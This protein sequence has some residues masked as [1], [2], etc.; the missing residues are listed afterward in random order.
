MH[1]PTISAIGTTA[2]HR[3]KG[4]SLH[5]PRPTVRTGLTIA[6]TTGL[7]IAQT[8]DLTIARTTDPITGLTIAQTTAP[9]I[10][11]VIDL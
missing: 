3:R 11:L 2:G 1:S 4:P 9:A 10:A 5:R 7:T 6:Q 8:T